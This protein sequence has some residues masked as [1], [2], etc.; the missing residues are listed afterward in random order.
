MSQTLLA[1]GVGSHR[2]PVATAAAGVAS[3]GAAPAGG[4][5]IVDFGSGTG[6]L[7]LP[8]AWRYPHCT[9]VL[10][11]MK[12]TSLELARERADEAGLANVRTVEGAPT[13][14]LMMM[15]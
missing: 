12:P 7:S 13:S 1:R 3:P 2:D 6:A 10:V 8:L 5:V 9:F 4:P 14:S 15:N 11:D